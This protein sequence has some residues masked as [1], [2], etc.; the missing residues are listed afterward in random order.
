MYFVLKRIWGISL[1]IVNVK[2]LTAAAAAYLN[3]IQV[4]Y[5][6]LVALMF[7]LRKEEFLFKLKIWFKPE[8]NAFQKELRK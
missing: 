8:R 7:W 3:V 4:F 2:L 6:I 5:I 1:C